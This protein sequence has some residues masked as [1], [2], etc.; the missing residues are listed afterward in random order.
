MSDMKPSVCAILASSVVGAALLGLVA[1]PAN[2]LDRDFRLHNDTRGSQ[3]Y[4]RCGNDTG[5]GVAQFQTRSFS[6][7]GNFQVLTDQ[8]DDLVI[9]ATYS[10]NCSSGQAKKVRVTQQADPYTASTSCESS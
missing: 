7:P 8:G 2:A 1:S 3:I 9:R 5:F 4:G 10:F 6:C